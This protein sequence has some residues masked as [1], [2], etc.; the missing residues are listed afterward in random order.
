MSQT[1]DALDYI[2]SKGTARSDEIA[3]ACG[4]RLAVVS[5]LLWQSVKD[6]LLV[7]C[8]V[9]RPRKPPMNEYR[10][11]AGAG[12]KA[13]DFKPLTRT[14]GQA[15]TEA[16]FLMKKEKTF[17]TEQP[18][19]PNVDLRRLAPP[20]ERP[21]D[22]LP[23]EKGIPMPEPKVLRR[24]LIANTLRALE[25][26][27]SFTVKLSTVSTVYRRSKDLNISIRIEKTKDG[28]RARIWRAA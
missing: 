24:N 11:A 14:A 20:P 25:P 1:Q 4:L 27:D 3:A 18:S 6:G 23:I 26:S 19:G 10:F 22:R 21:P 13:V 7:T 28:K 2:R 16:R 12:G 8:K 15:R 9:E 5:A 17:G